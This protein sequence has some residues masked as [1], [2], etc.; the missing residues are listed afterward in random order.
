MGGTNTHLPKIKIINTVKDLEIAIDDISKYNIIAYD[1]ETTGLS[2][3]YDKI[4]LVSIAVSSS[5]AYV[6][7][8][9]MIGMEHF[10]KLAPVLTNPKILKLLFNAVFDF[11]MSLSIAKIEINNMFDSMLADQ[12]LTAGLFV[13]GVKGKQFSL[14]AVAHRRL[15]VPMNK[16]IRNEFIGYQGKGF[17]QEA[18]EY[19]ADDTKLLFPI[20]EQ[21]IVEIKAH[22]LERICKLEMDIIPVTA[23]ME[24]TGIRVDR[25]KLESLVEPFTHYVDDCYRALQDVFISNGVASNI[26]FDGPQYT[27]VNP[28]SKP[29][30]TDALA[31]MGITPKSLNAKDVV[32][33]DFKNSNREVE[34]HFS[35]IIDDADLADAIEKYGG[36][37]NPVLRLFAFYTGAQKLLGTYVIKELDRIDPNTQRRYGWFKS[38]GARSTGRYSSDMQQKPKNDKLKRLG[39]GQYSIRE[40]Y[41]ASPNANLIIA[42]YSGIELYILAD[43][44]QDET[45][46]YDITQGDIH[47]TVT[48]ATLGNYLPVAKEIN[49]TNKK[50]HPF[51]L[52]RDASKTLSYGIAYGVSGASLADQMN[53]KL[54]SLGVSFS[55]EMGDELIRLW[56]EVAFPNAGKWLDETGNLAVVRG[57]V[58]DAWGRK[59]FFDLEHIKDNKWKYFAAQREGKNAPIQMTS[60]T[61]TKRAMQLT[62]NRL[63]KKRGRILLAVHDEIVLEASEKYTDTAKQILKESMEQAGQETMPRMGKYVVISPDVSK[64][65]DK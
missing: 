10:S 24:L 45:L 22:N 49:D 48:R 62:Y 44:S 57:Y 38:L 32:Q 19:A 3:L 27:A 50:K 39:L 64:R 60:A 25:E 36:L 4:L 30:M 16:D 18:Y 29:Q 13:P 31:G 55:P 2:P 34:L 15:G 37:S 20:Y 42:D 7:D 33:W 6:I 1:L 5:L 26:T 59:R 43:R 9:T 11:K 46:E 54:A 28:A 14:E 35:D 53:I 8:F 61:M 52:I 12:L 63:D 40:C 23:V 21:Q 65:Y 58:D 17:R 51:N 56:K 41:I 47:L